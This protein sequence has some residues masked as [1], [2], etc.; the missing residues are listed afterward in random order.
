MNYNSSEIN[1]SW[2][3]KNSLWQL[4]NPTPGKEN[5]NFIGYIDLIIK[6]NI[7]NNIYIYDFKTSTNGW[8]DYQKN[9][10]NKTQQLVLYKKFY[11]E[12]FNIP[13]DS[14]YVEFVILKRKLYENINYVQ[15]RV[16]L[17]APASGKI[18]MKEVTNKLNTFLKENFDDQD[19]LILNRTFEKNMS[20]KSCMFCPFN[21]TENCDAPKIER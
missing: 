10:E 12:Q 9:D 11:S 4:C 20:R 15:K 21:G 3:F 6:D 18:K 14:I 2:Q 8:K 1:K 5:V 7:A 17:F 16:Q 13:I 19:D